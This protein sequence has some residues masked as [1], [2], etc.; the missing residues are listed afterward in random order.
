MKYLVGMMTLT[1]LWFSSANAEV[2]TWPA[3]EGDLIPIEN[4]E[5]ASETGHFLGS[6]VT[7]QTS[8]FWWRSG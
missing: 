5:A 4:C 3:T 6:E 8:I 2:I 1:V 7:D